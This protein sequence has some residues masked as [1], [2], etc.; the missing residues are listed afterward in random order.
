MRLIHFD[1]NALELWICPAGRQPA[2]G[3]ASRR[4]AVT[5]FAGR[6]ADVKA[7]QADARL[8][9]FQ[10]R[11]DDHLGGSGRFLLL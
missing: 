1:W 7:W 2:A 4:N 6:Q 8:T 10:R 9:A 3:E 11:R 5:P